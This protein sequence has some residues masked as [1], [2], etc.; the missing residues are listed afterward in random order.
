MSTSSSAILFPK[1]LFLSFEPP[2]SWDDYGGEGAEKWKYEETKKGWVWESSL[3]WWGL[4]R[5]DQDHGTEADRPMTL[6]FAFVGSGK[7]TQRQKSNDLLWLLF[8]LWTRFLPTALR[9][10]CITSK[11]IVSKK[12]LLE[13]QGIPIS[14]SH[15]NCVFC[16]P[17][18]NTMWCMS[19]QING[20]V[21]WRGNQEVLVNEEVL[22]IQVII[23]DVP[24]FTNPAVFFNIVQNASDP[25]PSFQ[26]FGRFSDRL[27]GSKET[28]LRLDNVRHWSEESISNIT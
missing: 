24:L 10:I 13:L 11:R 27:G 26:T 23:K 18:P 16:E 21:F 7:K 12:T 3:N 9:S 25:P 2:F 1:Y 5:A 14:A 28:A 17:F 19:R 22:F 8:L 20:N 15:K 6:L 4:L